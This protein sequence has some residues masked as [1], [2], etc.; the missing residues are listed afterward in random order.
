MKGF[1]SGSAVRNLPAMQET[2]EIQIQSLGRKIPQRREWQ[3]TPV[4]SPEKS[5]GQSS[6]EGSPWDCKESGMTE[7]T[8]HEREHLLKQFNAFLFRST[9]LFFFS[10]LWFPSV[11][12]L[13]P[14]FELFEYF[15]ILYSNHILYFDISL[16]IMFQY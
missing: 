6:P 8:E 15:S 2:Q 5:Q 1:P 7:V 9:I 3:P 4:F 14:F 16:R 10:F 13:M 12:L 11:G